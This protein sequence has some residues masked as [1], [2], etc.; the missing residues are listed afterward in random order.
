MKKLL[1]LNC[2]GTFHKTYNEL[3]GELVINNNCE[4][5][6]SILKQTIRGNLDFEL[7]GIIYKDSLEFTTQDREELVTFINEYEKV[8]IV[9][10]TDTMDITASFIAKRVKNKT[11]ILTGAMIPYSIN[12]I[13][14]TSNLSMS[15]YFLSQTSEKGVYIGMHGLVKEHNKIYKNRDLGIF[16]CQ[17]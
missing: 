14:A 2:G 11:I 16:L 10:G 8:L 6:E 4:T 12:P 5:L 7:K 17:K 1:V 15:L 9:H 3:K 13:E